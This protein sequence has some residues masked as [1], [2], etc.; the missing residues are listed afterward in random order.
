KTAQAEDVWT[1]SSLHLKMK[2][3]YPYHPKLNK[4]K[5]GFMFPG[6]GSQYVDMMKDLACKYQVVQDTFDEADEI[7]KNLIN[8]TLTEV[9]FSKPG[10]TKEELERREEAIKQT[11][12]TQP[13][14]L[15]ADIAMLR[16]LETFDVKPDVV[17]GHS[18]GEYAAAIASGIFT[19]ENGI[20]AVTNRAKEMS[21]I[22]VADPGKMASIGAP[23]ERVEAELKKIKGYVTAANK[24]CP[25]QTVI[26][27]EKKAVEE[28]VKLFTALGIASVE[29]PVS[30]A[31]HS[32]IISSAVP[33]YRKFLET[34]PSSVPN[35]PILSNVTA[36]FFPSD[37]KAVR[38]LLIK[39]IT[40][41]VEWM[42]QLEKMYELGVRL[43]IECGPKRVLSAFATGTFHNKKDIFVLSSNHPKR[44]GIL[45]FNDLLANLMS[46]S[47]ELK[48]DDKNPL[49]SDELYSPVYKNWVKKCAGLP[50]EVSA[51]APSMQEELPLYENKPAQAA[52]HSGGGNEISVTVSGIAA[53]TPGKW[54][55]VFRE[56]N[57]DEILRGQNMIEPLSQD[58]RQKQIDKNVVYVV[59]SASG[60]HRIER[61]TSAEQAIKLAAQRGEFDLEKEFGLPANWVEIMDISSKLAIGAGILALKDAGIPLVRH[62]K[63]T[64]TGGYLPEQWGL[65]PEM[66]DDTGVIFTSAF[67]T[68]ETVVKEIS[69]HLIDKFSRKT[70]DEIY[71]VYDQIIQKIHDPQDRKEL[72]MWFAENF[73]K[74]HLGG[75][76]PQTFS[77]R[78][79]LKILPVGHTHF[80][81]WIRA[82][83]PATHISAAC[84]STAQAVGIAEDWIKLGRSKRVVIIAADVITYET[85]QEWTMAGFLASGAATTKGSVSEAALPFD[86]RRHGLIVGMGAIGMV[87]EDEAEV[88]KRGLKPLTRV[89]GTIF[90]NSA[91]HPTRLDVNHVA[92]LMGRLISQVEKTH[93]LSRAEMSK[94]M[95]FISHETYTPARG[96]SASAEVHALKQTFGENAK[97]IIVSNVK[98]FTGHTMGASL[99]EVVAV[100]AVNTGIIPP[101]ANYKEPDP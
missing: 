36:D 89:L 101:I 72:T 28:A 87:L 71:A 39:Q 15:T 91:F 22:K 16:L 92:Y 45:E 74:H 100:R 13:A 42:S 66:M 64:S 24:N 88:K 86:K 52:A 5:I 65:A 93:G 8:T 34:I 98:G 58:E 18:L 57:I 49:E 67:P 47:V 51:T 30:H 26:A 54:D 69:R 19:F 99:E 48:W 9:V 83:G 55:R 29:I 70:A 97:N 46:A 7:L 94:K 61:L 80:C 3:I 17:M 33:P 78:F 81:Q 37:E 50:V 95:L 31:F 53:G 21:N 44:G 25:T 6:Q 63:K 59:K 68:F 62:Y 1:N 41:T 23:C 2:G 43:F 96:G 4:A 56:G 27:G 60:D 40:S 90:A 38:E 20:R 79:L 85:S 32:E 35:I 10:E 75:G 82:R 84:S 76:D 77:Q 14:V 12:M 11:Q 73:K